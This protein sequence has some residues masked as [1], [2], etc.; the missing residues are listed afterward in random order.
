[1]MLGQLVPYKKLLVLIRNNLSRVDPVITHARISDGNRVSMELS[2][3]II[4]LL[5]EA[6]L[7]AR[8]I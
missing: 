2:P 6:T 4:R 3:M 5:D 1:M 7:L 8:H